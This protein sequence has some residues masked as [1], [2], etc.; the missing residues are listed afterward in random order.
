M[1][2]AYPWDVPD[3]DFFSPVGEKWWEY[4]YARFEGVACSLGLDPEAAKLVGRHVREIIL[5]PGQYTLYEDAV[6][7]LGK[8]M[9]LG[10]ENYVL[11]NNYPE[12]A[13][14]VEKLHI[15]SYFKGY[16]V[17][18]QQ[19]FDKPRKELFT[20]ALTL[21]GNPDVC[22]MIG[23]NESADIAGGKSAGM[24]TVLMHNTPGKITAADYAFGSLSE[25][26]GILA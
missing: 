7:T 20:Y 19:G 23:D 11:S 2:N 4:M 24:K 6:P 1:H 16:I 9:R 14:T 12:L 26:I 17:S 8:C 21:A 25:I 22:Y 10:Y 3:Q 13:V 5:D 15:A 18:G